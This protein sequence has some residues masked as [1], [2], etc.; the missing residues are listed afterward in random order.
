M[1]ISCHKF[2]T[3]LKKALTTIHW[4]LNQQIL[5]SYCCLTVHV[6]NVVNNPILKK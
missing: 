4:D 1:I 3:V 5:D 2:N 6:V